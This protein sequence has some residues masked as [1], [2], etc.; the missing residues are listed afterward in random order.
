MAGIGFSGSDWLGI[1][2]GLSAQAVEGCGVP[3][4]RSDRRADFEDCVKR[5]D[6]LKAKE[7]DLMERSL[8][9]TSNTN[10]VKYI[11]I[12]VIVLITIMLIVKKR[13]Q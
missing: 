5:R 10:N 12:A 13:K 8:G 1:G 11:A 2:G 9:S 4:V 3:P 6:E 7:L